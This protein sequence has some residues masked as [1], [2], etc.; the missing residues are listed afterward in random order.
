MLLPILALGAYIITSNRG[1][2]PVQLL[3][4]GLVGFYWQQLAFL[5]H[6]AG[7]RTHVADRGEARLNPY[8]LCL[9]AVLGDVP[10][11]RLGACSVTALSSKISPG[12]HSS[13]LSIS[14]SPG[15]S[16]RLGGHL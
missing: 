10:C 15:L 4:A 6:D 14:A 12:G 16:Q 1:D 11:N 3:G 7:H 5:G 2:T 13:F 8:P 9:D